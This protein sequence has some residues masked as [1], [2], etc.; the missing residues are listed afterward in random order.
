MALRLRRRRQPPDRTGTMTVVEH[1]TELR[2]RLV[3]SVGAVFLGMTGGWFLYGSAFNLAIRPFCDFMTAHPQLARDPKDPCKVVFLS[4]TEPFLT[5]IKVV[6]FLG[7]ALALPII[8]FQLWRFITPGL[9]DRE[10]RF[11]IP[12]VVTSMLLF[13]LGGFFA[14]L[15]LPKGLA[16]LLGFAGTNHIEFVL[17]TGKYV[18]FVMLL[19]IAFG[20][21]FEFPLIL[22]S[23]TFVGVLSSRQLRDWRRYA[24]VLIAIVAAVITPSQDWFTMTALMVPLII[25]Y[26]L[27]IIVARL[28]KK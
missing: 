4:I 5:K 12:F 3:L 18:G 15:T 20:A 26:E 1:L 21:A 7:L 10:R 24:L 28:L 17:S 9:T 11:A 25:F 19:I 8:L 16:F 27:S 2:K 22:I 23:L 14:F 6:A 13:A